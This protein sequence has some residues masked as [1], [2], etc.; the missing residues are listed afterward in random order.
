MNKNLFIIVGSYPFGY[1]EPFLHEEVLSLSQHFKNIYLIIPSASNISLTEKIS[2]D[3]PLNVS[4][5][6]LKNSN[7]KFQKIFTFFRYG[8]IKLLRLVISDAKY[9]KTKFTINMFKI[10]FYY[11]SAERD[12]RIR[13]LRK[14]REM[15]IQDDQVVLYSYWFTEFTYS[16]FQIKKTH[17]QIKVYT[18]MHG[19]DVYFERHHPPYL[20]LRKQIIEGMDGVFPVSDQAKQYLMYKFGLHNSHLEVLHMGVTSNGRNTHIYSSGT[21]N[22]LSMSMVVPVKNIELI[23][24]TLSKMDSNIHVKWTHFGGGDDYFMHIRKYANEKLGQKKNISFD[25]KGT[26]SPV[27]IREFMLMQS[28]DLLINTSLSEGL[29]VSMMEAMSVSIPVIGPDIG[30]IAE[31]IENGIN[32]YL[33]SSKP[34]PEEILN[35][36]NIY[37][38]MSNSEIGSMREKAYSKWRDHFN[39]QVNYEILSKRLLTDQ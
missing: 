14:I 6:H 9:T 38:A 8:P 31:I 7:S 39:A 22:L 33:L 4:A 24:D 19:W 1:K 12:I 15:N 11:L 25:F 23:I 5:I 16:L 10:L 27:E 30:G 21:I 18:R 34:T 2:Y 17:P 13:L 35:V 29:P 3:L 37:L 28:V 26:K 32:G 20:P 36:L